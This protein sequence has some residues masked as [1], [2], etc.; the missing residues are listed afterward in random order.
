MFDIDAIDE[1][2]HRDRA[3]AAIHDPVF[4]DA[5]AGVFVALNDQV[6]RGIVGV[7]R[8]RVPRKTTRAEQRNGEWLASDT[9]SGTASGPETGSEQTPGWLCEG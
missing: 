9:S 4:G 8:T 6:A 1:R 2:Q 5:G 7:G 3:R